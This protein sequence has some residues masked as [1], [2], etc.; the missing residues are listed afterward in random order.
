MNVIFFNS[1]TFLAKEM[2]NALSKRN[3]YQ[4]IAVSIPQYPQ[5]EQVLSIFELLKPH[6]PGLVVIIN[7]AGSD[8]GGLLLDKISGTGSVIVNWYHDYPFYEEQFQN[9]L[10]RP[11]KNRVD[12][13]SEASFVPEMV[14]RGYN[15]HFLPLATD[16]LYFNCMQEIDYKRDIAFVGNSS[17]VFL[18]SIMTEA[19]VIELEKLLS[20]QVQLKKLYYAD[21]NIDL[22]RYLLENRKQWENKTCLGERE[23]LFLLEWLIG[24]FYR[25]DFIKTIAQLYGSQFTCFGDIYWQNIIEPSQVSTDAGYY[26]TLCDY[27][28]STKINLNINRIQIRKSFTQ[29]VFDC[30]A[31]GAFLLSNRRECNKDYFKVDGPDQE[32]VQFD[33]VEDCCKLIDY[34]LVHEDERKKITDAARANVLKNHTYDIR[35]E[36][37]IDTCTKQFGI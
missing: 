6:L 15:A 29:R 8:Y 25:R 34:Y 18:D 13:V 37:I 12:F 21:P 24:Y 11:L 14:Q 30:A 32:L 28:R 10:M 2:N 26:T 4:F 7:D 33:S 16:P 9:R 5:A 36:Q 23:L 31:S 27:Y 20:L 17:S 19:R 1:H 22:F 3:N 35:V